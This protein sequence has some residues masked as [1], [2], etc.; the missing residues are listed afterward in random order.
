MNKE[1]LILQNV[2]KNLKNYA[3]YIFAL[4]FSV[5]LYF[6]FV[7][8]QYDPAMDELEALVDG[9]II[10]NVGSI[11]LI[12]I[13]AAFVI[14][15]NNLFL[16]RRS[17]EIGLLQIVGMTKG[18]IFRLLSMENAI[19]YVG[20]LVIGIFFGFAA[21]KMTVMILFKIIAID[22][23][24]VLRFSPESLGQTVLLFTILYL[25]ILTMNYMFVH[26]QQIVTLFRASSTTE[27]RMRS[28][29][30]PTIVGGI[31]GFC[32]LIFAYILLSRLFSGDFPGKALFRAMLAIIVAII[33]GTYLFYKSSIRLFLHINRK[34]KDGY[35]SLN[36]VLSLSAIMF[37]MRSNALLLTIITLVSALAIGLSSLAYIAYYSTEKN[38]RQIAPHHFSIFEVDEAEKFTERLEKSDITY[39]IHMIPILKVNVDI[40]KVLVPGSFDKL[41]ISEDPRLDLTVISARSIEGIDVS[42]GEVLLTKPA[43]AYEG[44]LQFTDRGNIEVIGKTHTVKLKYAGMTSESVL[45]QRL[46]N[47]FPTVIV[48][49]DLYEQFAHDIDTSIPNPF[50]LYIAIDIAQVSQLDKANHIFHELDLNKWTGTWAGSESQLDMRTIQK[51]GMGVLIFISGFLGLTFLVTSGCIL[52]F[53]QID[54][55]EEEKAN[56]TILRKLGFTEADLLQGI[57]KKQLFNFGI[58]LVIGLLHSYFAVKSGWFIF[59]TEMWTPMLLVMGIYTILYSLFGM[60]SVRYYK[61]LIQK[62]L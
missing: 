30:V 20:S 14:Y 61:R 17:K 18:S 4:T 56:Y 16:K 53:K 5:A 37:R 6:S 39:T 59:G 45:H 58:P 24:T 55:S 48:H 9:K 1:H 7:T 22:A 38:A 41:D 46:T 12:F 21:S 43:D 42:P 2:R 36:D 3:L 50:P 26:R 52:Y 60:L 49:D 31:I 28:I 19:L 8:L 32:L 13:I 51:Q 44:M 54:E 35:V 34:R 27:E 47:G 40:T 57:R 25:I 29:S 11:F 62:A 10:M 15:A 23:V 33:I